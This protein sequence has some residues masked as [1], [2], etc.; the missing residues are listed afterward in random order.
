MPS[1]NVLTGAQLL[2]LKNDIAAN[3]AFVGMFAAE[4]AQV[5]NQPATPDFWVWKTNVT[6]QEWKTAMI[7]GGGANQLD[8]LTQSKRDS[9][10]W[11]VSTD[12][13]PSIAAVR[14]AID[15]F[16]GS[17]N[18]LKGALA[19]AQKRTATKAEKLFATG[20]G[21]QNNPAT[22]SFEGALT[23]Q[24]VEAAQAL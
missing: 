3:P 12:L 24:H 19:A 8:A 5:Y 17:Q 18:N 15:D 1:T 9:L 20:T 6:A 4:I 22:L 23:Y 16:C 21:Q 7:G 13:D 2:V 11:A 10:L 14:S